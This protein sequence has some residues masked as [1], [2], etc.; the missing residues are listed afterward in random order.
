M[1]SGYPVKQTR[2]MQK[3][4][5]AKQEHPNLTSLKIPIYNESKEEARDKTD[6]VVE[7]KKLGKLGMKEQP[8]IGQILSPV[9]TPLGTEANFLAMDRGGIVYCAKELTR[10][11]ATP[12][13]ADW[14]EMVRL[15][16]YLKK[17]T[18]GSVVVEISRNAVPT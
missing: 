8:L 1:E 7:R 5:S 17:Q 3:Q 9:E 16:R 6:D 11:M 4:S 15:V 2:N 10:H 13:T 14:E 18:Q 12:T